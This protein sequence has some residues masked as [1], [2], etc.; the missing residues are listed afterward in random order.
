MARVGDKVRV[1]YVC[2]LDDGTEV[3][4]SVRSGDPFEFVMGSE[5]VLPALSK[6]VC[7]MEPGD[8]KR[9]RLEPEEAYGTWD[10][11]LVEKVPVSEIPN[12]E[13]L[14]VGEYIMFYDPMGNIRVKVMGIE[15]GYVSFDHNHEL[16]DRP[17]TFDVQLL[18]VR[19]QTGSLVRDELETETGCS[20]G[21]NKLK[22]QLSGHD[23]C[24]D[25]DHDHAHEHGHALA[26]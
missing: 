4:S 21:C 13:D 14:P 6:L 9:V 15:D 10:P 19:G 16:A 22:A 25:H 11:S 3:D 1:R 20:C 26:S 2:T 17:L 12:A 8:R 7:S 24:C 23:D 5:R 18:S